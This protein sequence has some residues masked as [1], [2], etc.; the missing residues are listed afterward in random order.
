VTLQAYTAELAELPSRPLPLPG[1]GPVMVFVLNAAVPMRAGKRDAGSPRWRTERDLPGA[2][3]SPCG[4]VVD[5]GA[6]ARPG[7][8]PTPPPSL[9]PMTRSST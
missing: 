3:P 9:Q 5:A 8:S 2:A 4:G 1:D 7:L 6:I